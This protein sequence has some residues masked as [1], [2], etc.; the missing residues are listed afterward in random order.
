M[1]L[2]VIDM[3]MLNRIP[4]EIL[5][6]VPTT[7][8]HSLEGIPDLDWERMLKLQG[9]DGS[10]LFSPAA[11]AFAFIQT[12]NEKCLEYIQGIVERFNGGGNYK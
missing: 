11:T 6:E 10:F 8:L 4:K 5:H 3:Y 1:W 7:L 2:N 12:G 9:P